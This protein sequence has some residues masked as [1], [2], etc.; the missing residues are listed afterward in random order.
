M[1]IED[2]DS[3][4]D[5]DYKSLDKRMALEIITPDG[6]LHGN[7]TSLTFFDSD[8]SKTVRKNLAT[9][10]SNVKGGVLRICYKD[11]TKKEVRDSKIIG[12]V[13]IKNNR[14]SL[15]LE[16]LSALKPLELEGGRHPQLL[17]EELE[18]KL[19]IANKR[20]EDLKDSKEK[21][22]LKMHIRDLEKQIKD[23]DKPKEKKIAKTV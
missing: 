19:E 8:G 4:V 13:E 6:Q 9:L 15:Y 11:G 3:P 5:F 1:P 12:N 16:S 10:L 14:I 23:I 2:N 22:D 21:N 20:L 17:R 18:K 7:I